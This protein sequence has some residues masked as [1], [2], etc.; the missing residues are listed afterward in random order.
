[1]ATVSLLLK[2]LAMLAWTVRQVCP[3]LLLPIMIQH[4]SVAHPS[5]SC[6]GGRH[7]MMASLPLG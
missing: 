5:A 7:K 3:S 4:T 6:T 2:Q 1:M